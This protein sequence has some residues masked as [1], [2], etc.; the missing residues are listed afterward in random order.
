MAAITEEKRGWKIP[1]FTVWIGQALSLVGTAIARFAL[2]WW[3]T[4]QTGSA[5]VLAGSSLVSVAPRVLLGPMA[6][7]YIDRHNRRR[8]MIMADA[9]TGLVSL[10]LAIMFLT[11]S[12]QVWHVYVV[13]LARSLGS[14]FHGPAMNASTTLM[15]PEQQ[16]SRVAGMNQT[17]GGVMSFLGPVLGALSLELLPLHGVMLVDVGTAVLAIVAL[18]IIRIPNPER[19]LDENG[20]TSSMWTDLKEGFRY[21]L[22]WK[23]M[24]IF[25]GMAMSINFMISPAF[26]LMPLLVRNEFLGGAPELAMLQSSS[27]IG[28]LVGGLTL[29]IW[30][31][32]RRKVVTILVGTTLLGAAIVGLGVT[33][34]SIF[35]VAIASSVAMGFILPFINGTTGAMLQA[36]TAPEMQ[37]RVFTATES[38]SSMMMLVSLALAGPIAEAVGLRVMF[39]V[40]GL[41]CFLEG[42]GGFFIPAL[43]KVEEQGNE[44]QKRHS[45]SVAVGS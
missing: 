1:F 9:F 23:G 11:G 44:I 41:V 43:M 31:G 34:T 8:I 3:L 6:G 12:M 17:L 29:S 19:R 5:V 32:F 30:G 4:D 45:E 13:I 40:S 18:L 24:A 2:I 33:P 7:V 20:D 14:T 15:V 25:M 10:W 37:G 35:W 39:I 16:L 22:D 42:L 27:G 21:I 38:F 28:L 26:S 36:T